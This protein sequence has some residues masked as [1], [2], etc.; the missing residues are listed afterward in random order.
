M[1]T[2]FSRR[3]FVGGVGSVAAAL[4]VPNGLASSLIGASQKIR[5][6]YAAI[7]WGGHDVQAIKEVAEVGY[8]GIQLRSPMLKDF[9]NKRKE[10]RDLLA[11]NKLTFVAL[12]GGGPRNDAYVPS[13]E[14]ATQVT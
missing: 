6:G 2:R 5:F 12:S 9:G 7:T 1:S 14:I 13:E 10:L 8:R 11:Q 4:A 3:A